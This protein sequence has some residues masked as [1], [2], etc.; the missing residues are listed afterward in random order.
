[1]FLR[2]WGSTACA[3]PP[4]QNPCRRAAHHNYSLWPAATT[5]LTPAAAAGLPLRSNVV[6]NLR[7]PPQTPPPK[8]RRK[9]EVDGMAGATAFF[10]RGLCPLCGGGFRRCRFETLLFTPT[11]ERRRMPSGL[12]LALED[13][14]SESVPLCGTPKLF[15]FHFSLFPSQVPRSML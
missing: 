13:G 11:E 9:G 2:W 10:H 8:M 6:G 15:T 12:P 14:V 7:F 3:L 5:R 4:F 1:M